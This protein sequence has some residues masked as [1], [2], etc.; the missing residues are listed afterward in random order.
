MYNF[1]GET[2]Q[3]TAAW[4]TEKE[5]EENINMDILGIVLSIGGGWNWPRIVSNDGFRC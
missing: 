1:G 3:K 2:C 5:I 4:K